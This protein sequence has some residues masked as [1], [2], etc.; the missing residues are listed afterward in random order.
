M[1]RILVFLIVFLGS[2]NP[3]SAQL[4]DHE[5]G[6][7]S[8]VSALV[9]A[10]GYNSD[11]GFFAGALYARYNYK[12]DVQ[13]FNNH[14]ESSALFSTKGYI[15]VDA[16]FEQT[17]SFGTDIRSVINTFFHRYTSQSYFGI[18]N[19]TPFT[20]SRWEEDYY[21]YESVGIE[22][23]YTARKPLYNNA[24]SQFDVLG[25]IGTEY[26]TPSVNGPETSFAERMPNGSDGGWV[27]YLK[28][29]FIWENRNREFDPR[30]GNR[31][32]FEVRYSPAAISNYALTTMRLEFLQYIPLFDWLKAANRLELRHAAGD[33]PFWEMS[34]IGD[35][36]SL[37]GYPFNRFLGNSSVA[38]SLELRSWILTYPEL[39]NLKL[40]GQLFTDTGRVF[41][42]ENNFSDLFEGYKQTFGFGGAMSVIN[43]DLI[44][45]GDIG[46]SEDM[47]RVYIGVGYAF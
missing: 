29:G 44:L 27:N 16:R 19:D 43:P 11:Q 35:E 32:E 12:G 41:T 47:T 22:I 20:K 2:F 31:A 40:G 10:L 33:V 24:N 13:P 4:M 9:P 23:N 1:K 21:Y 38:Y 39:F 25:G 34:M 15:E 46:F 8:L 36:Q 3:L 7:D 18:G 14:L 45:R 30:R 6:A 42:P 37:R 17:R 26:Q 28:T 5:V